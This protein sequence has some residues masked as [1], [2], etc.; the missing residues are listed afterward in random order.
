L[1]EESQEKIIIR[2]SLI[3]GKVFVD[4]PDGMNWLRERGFGDSDKQTVL[5]PYEALYLASIGRLLVTDR[6]GR[7]V[8]F[9]ELFS[10]LSKKEK[11][12]WLQYLITR[13]LRTRGY[14]VKD[15]FGLGLDFSVYDRGD[16]PEKPSKLLV[17]GLSEGAPMKAGMMIELLRRAD[18]NR[19]T[20]VLAV[21]DRRSEVV[22][23]DISRLH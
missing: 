23:Y 10:R 18:A 1:E 16:Y 19:K 21:I 14:V 7:E 9:E 22:Y 6:R 12:L 11:S 17:V 3:G 4:S 15:G 13:D 20:L 2:G 8:N 5:A